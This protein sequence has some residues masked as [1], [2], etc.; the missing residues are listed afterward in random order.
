V[1]ESATPGTRPDDHDVV[2][3]V[4]CHVGFL[5]LWWRMTWVSAAAAR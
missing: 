5:M 1:P 3:L 2:V 4:I